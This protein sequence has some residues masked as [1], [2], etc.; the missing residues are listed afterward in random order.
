MQPRTARGEQT[1]R[2]GFNPRAETIR[3]ASPL[4]P[5]RAFHTVEA[6]ESVAAKAANPAR[7]S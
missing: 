2:A 5:H 4:L 7:R 1:A 3:Q 6:W